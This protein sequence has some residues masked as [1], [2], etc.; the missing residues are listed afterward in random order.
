ME[1]AAELGIPTEARPIEKSELYVAD[2]VFLSG[3]ACQVAWV[4]AIDKRPIGTGKIGPI[5]Q[6]LQDK[7][8]G[9]VRGADSDHAEW[10]TKVDLAKIAL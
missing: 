4:A 1:I 6:K 5:T 10:R 3:T 7:F 9:I 2:E 8:F